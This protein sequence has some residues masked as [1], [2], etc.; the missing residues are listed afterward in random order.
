MAPLTTLSRSAD[1]AICSLGRL[2]KLEVLTVFGNKGISDASV[3]TL[4][5][6]AALPEVYLWDTG[7]TAAG[8][9]HLKQLNPNL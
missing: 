4:G 7:V 2:D 6:M 8:L 9:K 5:H 3:D 1:Q